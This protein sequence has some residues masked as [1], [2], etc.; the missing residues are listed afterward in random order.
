MRSRGR[1]VILATH[2][3]VPSRLLVFRRRPPAVG[4]C[5]GEMERYVYGGKSFDVPQLCGS[6]RRIP[7]PIESRSA[8]SASPMPQ[9]R[10]RQQQAQERAGSA[11]AAVAPQ[12]DKELLA[13]LVRG[14][15][16]VIRRCCYTLKKR[17][18]VVATPE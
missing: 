17:L 13:D 5:G 9:T 10:R 6:G 1:N 18:T 15:K 11:V 4:A 16:R 3:R 7:V 12:L 2:A 14:A 8:T